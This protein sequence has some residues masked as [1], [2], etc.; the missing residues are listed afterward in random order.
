MQIGFYFDQTRCTGCCA[1]IVA[2]KDWHD[3]SAGP[4]SWIKVMAIERGKYPNPFLC[5]LLTLCWHCSN[6]VCVKAC[7]VKAIIKRNE[8]GIITVD[9]ESCIGGE[10]CRFACLKTCP[11]DVP[12]FS[13]ETNP[14]M[15]KCD[16]CLERW[17][18]GKKPICVE[19]CPMRALDAGPLVELRAKYGNFQEAKGFTYYNRVQPSVVFRPKAKL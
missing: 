5:Y 16:F 19:A 13:A 9:K 14:K 6:P 7:P 3:I 4:A 2:C 12:Q 1:C 10:E 18:E 17:R 15:Q 8:D 11:Y